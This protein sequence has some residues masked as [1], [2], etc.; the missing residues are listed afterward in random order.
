[1]KYELHYILGNHLGS[2]IAVLDDTGA[3]D[4]QQRYTPFGGVRSG[5]GAV[6]DTDT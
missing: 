6:S 5:I 4:N 3:L 2:T 1:M